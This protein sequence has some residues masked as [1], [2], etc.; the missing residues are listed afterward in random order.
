MPAQLQ[1]QRESG[2]Y[3]Q[4]EVGSEQARV[5]RAARIPRVSRVKLHPPQL[6]AERLALYRTPAAER[7]L[8]ILDRGGDVLD[9]F[10]WS[11]AGEAFFDRDIEGSDDGLQGSPGPVRETT[12]TLRIPI[13]EQADFLF[14]YGSETRGPGDGPGIA[15][16]EQRPLA[17]YY[18]GAG[19]PPPI[20]PLPIP[21]PGPP[22]PAPLPL[23]WTTRRAPLDDILAKASRP[24]W[25]YVKDVQ[26][27]VSTGSPADQF[28]IVILGDGFQDG[29]LPTFDARVALIAGGLLAIP[30]FDVLAPKINIHV[31][32]A[33]STDSGITNCPA[34][35]S[36]ARRTYFN[37]EGNFN[38][39]YPGFVGT[40][41]PKL[42]YQAAELIAPLEQLE[43]FLIIANCALPG[44]SAFPDLELAY[45]TMWPNAT[46]FV[47]VAAHE[48]AH[49]IAKLSEEYIGCEP[50][51]PSKTY[52]NRITEE[53]KQADDVWW[54]AL[55]QPYELQNNAFKAVHTFGEPFDAN[56]EPVVEAGLTGMLGLY[57]GCQDI[58]PAIQG[59]GGC[60]PFQDPRGAPFHRAMA[61]CK[62][63]RRSHPFCRVCSLMLTEAITNATP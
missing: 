1:E 61:R 36:G 39:L 40:H 43:L 13:R 57:W 3:L 31:V 55:A 34:V 37:V 58:D 26:T 5:V 8:A 23:P 54:K 48:A 53:Q 21:L 24:G 15:R 12:Q 56:N 41:T 4:I 7:V 10:G 14:F 45:V 27:I 11:A 35:S 32:L 19:E 59:P 46:D 17:L 29:E 50:P 6:T 28:D 60:D 16:L 30:P 47:N 38:G 22:G 2:I 20:P 52:P 9:A 49:A 25:G 33:V 18:L 42:I 44:G 63:R 62:M 51:D